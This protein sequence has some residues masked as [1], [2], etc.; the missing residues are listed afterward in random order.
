MNNTN[1]KYVCMNLICGLGADEPSPCK[2][3]GQAVEEL[4]ESAPFV[5]GG[6]SEG[7]K[8]Y[9][10]AMADKAFQSQD[11]NETGE[12]VSGGKSLDDKLLPKSK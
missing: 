2:R 7:H 9:M 6:I 4:D 1:K 8:E 10:Q 3:C 5:P 11:T 12:A